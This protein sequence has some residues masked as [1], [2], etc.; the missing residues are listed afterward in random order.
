ME[1]TS[2]LQWLR[3]RLRAVRV[4]RAGERGS[5]IFIVLLVLTVLTGIG[6]FATQSAGLNQ[7]TSGYSRQATQTGFV[8][9]YAALAAIDEITTGTG[10]PKPYLDQMLAAKEPCVSNQ[11]IDAASVG[12]VACYRLYASELQNRLQQSGNNAALFDVDGGSLGPGPQ[13][14][15][16]KKQPGNAT[17][18]FVVELTDPGAAGPVTGTDQGGTGV[19]G[20][21]VQIVVTGIAQVRPRSTSNQCTTAEDQYAAQSAGTKTTRAIVKVGPIFQ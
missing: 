18:D 9:D 8:A 14:D 3:R 1:L 2:R 17:A 11:Y 10:G 13:Y 4:S 15:L 20:K 12:V 7:R 16:A 21:Y 5:A 6:V 19:T